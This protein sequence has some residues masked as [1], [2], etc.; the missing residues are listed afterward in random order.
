M[1]GSGKFKTEHMKLAFHVLNFSSKAGVVTWL[2]NREH[3][4]KMMFSD[5]Q[6]PNAYINLNLEQVW[7]TWG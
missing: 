3:V 1:G 6:M 7:Y 2:I 5:W 4:V